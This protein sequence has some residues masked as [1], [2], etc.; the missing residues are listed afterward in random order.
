MLKRYYNIGIAIDTKSGLV[1][2]NIKD[3][4]EKSIFEIA[5]EIVDLVDRAEQR[6]LE[7]RRSAR[8]DVH[9]SPTTAR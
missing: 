7:L 9:Q 1:V 4:D 3:A 8:G 6:S 2:P 5:A